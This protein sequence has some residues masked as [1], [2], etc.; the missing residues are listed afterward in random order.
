M[1]GKVSREQ[2]PPRREEQESAHKPQKEL[3]TEVLRRMEEEMDIQLWGN[4]MLE[5][6]E[7]HC[8]TQTM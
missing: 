6:G 1:E 7:S 5:L 8:K 3:Q 4:T 2:V